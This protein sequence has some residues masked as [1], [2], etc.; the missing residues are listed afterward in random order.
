M[1]TAA[2]RLTGAGDGAEAIADAALMSDVARG[3]MGAFARGREVGRQQAGARTPKGAVPTRQPAT[4]GP[5]PPPGHLQGGCAQAQKP[6]RRKSEE[7]GKN[8]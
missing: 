2:M 8:H 1:S 5:P 3:D 4:P 7:K 6:P